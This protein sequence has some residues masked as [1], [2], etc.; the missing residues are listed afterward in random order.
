M[1]NKK[2]RDLIEGLVCVAVIVDVSDDTY[3]HCN[4][5]SLGAYPR[6]S[7]VSQLVLDFGGRVIGSAGQDSSIKTFPDVI[8]S[9]RVGTPSTRDL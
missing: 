6:L 7:V 9:C 5:H 3:T 2:P 4:L 1:Q 8:D